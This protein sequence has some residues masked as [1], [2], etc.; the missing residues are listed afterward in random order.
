[1]GP[2]LVKL[3]VKLTVFFYK[4]FHTFC[5]MDKAV[6]H[7]CHTKI[8]FTHSHYFYIARFCF[9]ENGKII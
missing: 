2:T 5:M 4:T 6:K 8:M 3:N 9:K 1:M 7:I